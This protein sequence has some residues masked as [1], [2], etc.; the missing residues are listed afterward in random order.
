MTSDA[1]AIE[2]GGERPYR[3]LVGRELLGTAAESVSGAAQAAVLYAE[4]V[5]VHAERV[6]SALRDAGVVPVPVEVPDA[7][8]GKMIE[9][10]AR[11]WDT[12]GGAAF[13][14]TDAVVGVGGGAV[15][16]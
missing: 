12:L 2:V 8:A 9:V 13:T 3:V 4:P 7:E 16:D 15:T 6:A 11:C 1:T 10:A 14:R 5:R